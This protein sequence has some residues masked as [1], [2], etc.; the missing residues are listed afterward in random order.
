MQGEA[1]P[2]RPDLE[3]VVVGMNLL[4]ARIQATGTVGGQSRSRDVSASTGAM[5]MSE[6][7]PT[8]P[9]MAE[10]QSPAPSA[11]SAWPLRVMA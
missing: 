8:M 11:S 3:Q 10:N 5:A 7:V 1:A 6:M 2:A 9:P 4:D